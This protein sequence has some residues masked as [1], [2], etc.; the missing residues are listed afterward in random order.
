MSGGDRM[1]RQNRRSDAKPFQFRLILGVFITAV[2][3]N[4][5]FVVF[6]YEP[7]EVMFW[8]CLAGA[9]FFLFTAYCW[10]DEERY[11]K[12]E[13]YGM[14]VIFGLFFLMLAAFGIAALVYYIK[15]FATGDYV[16]EDLLAAPIALG[17]VGM[18][19]F[20]TFRFSLQAYFKKKKRKRRK[21]KS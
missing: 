20:F 16:W 2:L 10:V 8:I 4:L 9:A 11:A 17:S 18:F 3:L 1:K 12:Y 19:A 14:P 15:K 7:K 21:G 6:I 5:F 13:Y